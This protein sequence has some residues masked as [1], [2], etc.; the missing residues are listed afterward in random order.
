MRTKVIMKEF[1]IMETNISVNGKMI[2]QMEKENSGMLM[3]TSTTASVK[4][5]KQKGMVCILPVTDQAI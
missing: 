1:T 2:E 4:L 5:I 3:V